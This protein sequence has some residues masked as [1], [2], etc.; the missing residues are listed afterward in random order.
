[1][2]DLSLLFNA[3][4]LGAYGFTDDASERLPRRDGTHETF[5]PRAAHASHCDGTQPSLSLRAPLLPLFMNI[6]LFLF[7]IPKP[8]RF[9]LL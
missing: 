9:M 6:C 4:C 1:M 3:L 2:V 7:V 8:T 5:H